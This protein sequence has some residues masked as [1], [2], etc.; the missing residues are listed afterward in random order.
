MNLDQWRKAKDLFDAALERPLD[1]RLRFLEENCDG[2]EELC[3]E[4]ESLLANSEDANSFL[5]QPALLLYTCALSTD[6]LS[7]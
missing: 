6:F 1:E 7:R 5:S 2:D 3:R 4:V